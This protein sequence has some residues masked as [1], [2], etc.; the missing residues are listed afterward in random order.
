[1]TQSLDT[2]LRKGA[3]L[4]RVALA[5]LLAV[6]LVGATVTVAT[7]ETAFAVTAEELDPNAQPNED[8]PWFYQDA[9]SNTDSG[10]TSQD[11]LISATN[12]TFGITNFGNMGNWFTRLLYSVFFG[13]SI[14]N[15]ANVADEFMSLIGSGDLIGDVFTS[16]RDGGTGTY[17]SALTT[18]MNVANNVVIPISNGFLG[19]SLIFSLMS[20]GREAGMGGRHGTDLFAGYL[21]IAVK[22][23]LI[24]SCITHSIS[25]MRGIFDLVNNIGSGIQQYAGLNDLD[26]NTFSNTMMEVCR[27]STYQDGFG[28][29]F[30]LLIIALVGAIAAAL[31]AVYAQVLIVV[32]V[33]EICILMCFSGIAFVM[34]GHQGTRESGIRYIKRFGS[35]CVQALVLLLVVGLGTIFMSAA[36]NL[37]VSTETDTIL[38]F[39]VSAVG[40]IVSCV[41]IFLMVKQSRDIANAIVGL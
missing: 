18:V 34:L 12:A 32:R 38:G 15:L 31:T 37:F 10:D 8:A 41:A 6:L 3:A 14:N 22:Y 4:A 17:T 40:P 39:I 7:P 33:F 36:A 5:C 24:S 30:V 9:Y 19:L 13:P 1:M 23:V 28:V 21:W 26:F 25:I 2:L 20:F 29:L 11:D 35:C 16:S 27:S